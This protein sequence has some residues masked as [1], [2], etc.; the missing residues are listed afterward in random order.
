MIFA[1]ELIGYK[2]SFSQKATFFFN[3]NDILRDRRDGWTVLLA[4]GLDV[5]EIPPVLEIEPDC[6]KEIQ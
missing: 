4:W 5:T 2:S 6:D 1:W 3:A